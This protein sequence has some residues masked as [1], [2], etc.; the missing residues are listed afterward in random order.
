MSTFDLGKADGQRCSC[1]E[2]RHAPV[3]NFISAVETI[4]GGVLILM[5]SQSSHHTFRLLKDGDRNH[6][7]NPAISLVNYLR[8]TNKDIDALLGCHHI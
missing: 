7:H 8:K 5:V 6:E 2:N 1:G 4:E 3:L